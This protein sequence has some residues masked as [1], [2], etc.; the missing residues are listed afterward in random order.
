MFT[1]NYTN[2][3]D[4]GVDVGDAQMERVGFGSSLPINLST[5]IQFLGR[6]QHTLF[7]S[8]LYKLSLTGTIHD[9]G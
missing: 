9:G 7:V 1:V 3:F 5:P 4:F 2:F 6:T 8:Q